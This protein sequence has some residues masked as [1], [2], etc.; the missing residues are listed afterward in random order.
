MKFN[1]STQDTYI[2]LLLQA[3]E[4]LVLFF[5]CAFHINILVSLI[6]NLK[7]LFSNSVG[8]VFFFFFGQQI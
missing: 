5:P 4:Q 3:V 2:Y 7:Y 8:L 6:G 1:S